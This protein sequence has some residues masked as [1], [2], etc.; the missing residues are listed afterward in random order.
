MM[1][2]PLM[3]AVQAVMAVLAPSSKLSVLPVW[4]SMIRTVPAAK[5]I[6]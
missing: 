2:V 5:D 3:V 1:C 4:Q 6:S